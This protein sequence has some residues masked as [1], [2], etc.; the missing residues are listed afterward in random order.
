MEQRELTY[1]E[2]MVGLNFNPG[3]RDD[4]REVKEAFAGVIDKLH[5]IYLD[6]GDANMLRLCDIAITQAQTAQMWAV[7]AI[8]FQ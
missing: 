1:G 8:T 6:T 7:K 3:G 5:Q 4:V 2:L